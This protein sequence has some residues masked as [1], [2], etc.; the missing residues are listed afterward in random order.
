MATKSRKYNIHRMT[1]TNG[2]NIYGIIQTNNNNAVG[3]SKIHYPAISQAYWA[4]QPQTQPYRVPGKY[5]L[6]YVG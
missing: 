3:E 4:P 2:H 6:E 1:P 5:C